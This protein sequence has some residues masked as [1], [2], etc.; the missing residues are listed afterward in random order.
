MSFSTPS[1]SKPC[2]ECQR[3]IRTWN[4]VQCNNEA[5]CDECWSKERP[6]RPGAVG[7]DGRP[8]EKVDVE[9]VARLTRIFGNKRTPEEQEAL[10]VSDINTTW[11]GLTKGANHMQGPV[12][13]YSGRMQDIMAESHTGQFTER[14]PHL[15]SFVGQ[16]GRCF[17]PPCPWR[18]H[19]P[20]DD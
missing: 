8:H 7:I 20:S 15:V 19:T 13:Y 17:S 9:V 4:C 14:F 2:C 1:L 5:F 18:V 12:L 11:F 10:H 3:P 6:H 16:T